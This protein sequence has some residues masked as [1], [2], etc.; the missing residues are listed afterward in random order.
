MEI[1]SKQTVSDFI[2]VAKPSLGAEEVTAAAR[3]IHSG[4]VSQGP[5]VNAFEQEFATL[6]GSPYA[7]A[8]ANG[9]TALHLALKAAGV[10]AGD[11][12]I[13]ASHSFIATANAI[14]HCQAIPV[15]VDID[16]ITFNIRAEDIAKAITTRT[17]AILCVHQLGL[18]CD[19]QAILKLAALHHIPV[20]EDAACAIGSEIH[21]DGEWQA[22]GR[23]HGDIACFSFHP[24]KVITTGEGGM[25][26]TRHS[27]WDQL[28]RLWRQHGM[29]VNDNTRH[30]SKSVIFENY[31]VVGYNYRLTDIQ[32]AMGR[33]QLK[34]LAD[35]V[36][37]RRQ[38]AQWYT[39][40]LADVS[41]VTPPQE[42][43]YAR[44]NWQSYAIR[45]ADSLDQQ[46]V[47]QGLLDR[48]IASRRGVMCAHREAAYQEY[49]SR[50]DLFES[51][52]AQDHVILLPIFPQLQ[53]D[54][55]V[56]IVHALKE[57]IGHD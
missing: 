31:S 53:E 33:E 1:I 25:L 26:T 12:V 7:C 21:F 14:V 15:F 51:E 40:L 42:P 56:R 38:L 49:S 9:T 17:K 50:F 36:E 48:G 44:Y 18:P 11:E 39:T 43:T 46:N 8:V 52:Q 2:P 10:E 54:Q 45:L 16:A 19:M 30:H 32:A 5:E 24:R 41:E 6:V 22:I 29:S 4:W 27:E 23:P 37:R 55:I 3:V 20:I 28:F 57:V 35:I 34:K 13:T 47:M